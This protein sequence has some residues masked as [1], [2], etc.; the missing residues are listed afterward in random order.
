MKTKLSLLV[1]CCLTTHLL[2]AQVLG[3]QRGLYIN[4]FVDLWHNNAPGHINNTINTN[5]SILGNTTAE[6][7]LL[8]YCMENHITYLVLYDMAKIFEGTNSAT[9]A[10][11][12]TALKQ[13]ICKAKR[14]YCIKYVGASIGLDTY[15]DVQTGFGLKQTPPYIFD[16]ILHDTDLYDSLSYVEDT[17]PTDD[18]RFA[19]AELIK[20]SLRI[21]FMNGLNSSAAWTV[22][23]DE[24]VD[25]LVTEYEF[26]NG[27]DF[28]DPF[29]ALD[30][31]GLI[32]AVDAIRNTH[33]A[34]TTNSKMYIETY[35]GRLAATVPSGI[36]A[37]D[38]TEYIDGLDVDG[39]RRID[40]IL[41]DYYTNNPI[42]VY[43]STNNFYQRR[44]LNF[45]ESTGGSCAGAVST[46]DNTDYHPIF[47]AQSPNVGAGVNSNSL[48]GW[49]PGASDRNIFTVEREFYNNF[50]AD[51]ST[52]VHAVNK[53]NDVQPGACQWLGQAYMVKPLNHPIT[54][55]SS[56]VPC[57]STG[58]QNVTLTYQGPIENADN[59]YTGTNYRY[60]VRN[61]LNVPF[62]P[63][64]GSASGVVNFTANTTGVNNVVYSLPPGNYEASLTLTY[65]TGCYYTYTENIVVSEEFNIHALNHPGNIVGPIDLCANEHVILQA[66]WQSTASGVSYAWMLNGVA[67]S[68]ANTYEYSATL[69]GDYVCTIT[70]TT[71]ST[72]VSNVIHVNLMASPPRFIVATCSS[73]CVTLTVQPQLIGDTYSWQDLSNASTFPS[74]SSFPTTICN[75][76]YPTFTVTV[77]NGGCSQT[78]WKD[79]DDDLLG[80]TSPTASTLTSDPDPADVCPG[81]LVELT[82]NASTSTSFL[83]S[84]GQVSTPTT[85]L[86]VIEVS[87]P[88]NYFVITHNASGCEAISN[89]IDVDNFAPELVLTAPV[90]SVCDAGNPV[91]LTVTGGTTTTIYTWSTGVT[92]QGS[93][94]ATLTVNPTVTTTYS[95]TGTDSHGC[96]NT[97]SVTINV[98]T[99][100]GCYSLSQSVVPAKT[101]A[102]HPVT[103]SIEVCNNTGVSRIVNLKDA[104]P[105]TTGSGTTFVYLSGT[106]PSAA[107]TSTGATIVLPASPQCTTY[108]VTGYFVKIHDCDETGISHSSFTNTTTLTPPSPATVLTSDVCATIL[109]D[110][111]MRIVGT[112]TTCEEDDDVTIALNIHNTLI[113]VD[114][115][116][117]T[118]IYPSFLIPPNTSQLVASL[119]YPYTLTPPPVPTIG[120][121]TPTT[122]V[123]N[124]VSYNQVSLQVSFPDPI[125]SNIYDW[126]Y[127]IKFKID[128]GR[129]AGQNQFFVA[130]DGNLST[131]SLVGS[132]ANFTQWTQ[133]SDIFLINCDGVT[134][135]FDASFSVSD[136]TCDNPGE[137][138]FTPLGS[139]P[140]TAIHIWDLG[141]DRRTPIRGENTVTWD[142]LADYTD[143]TGVP[144][145]RANGNYTFKVKHTVI[146][147][148]NFSIDSVIVTV[149]GK[150]DASVSKTD[151]ICAGAWAGTA[152]VT[153]TFGT[154]PYEY[155]W[156]TGATTSS[157]SGLEAGNY[158]VTV[159]DDIRCEKVVNFIIADPSSST[160]PSCVTASVSNTSCITGTIVSWTAATGCVMGYN[161]YYGTDG[162]GT[163]TPTQNAL[164]LGNVTS[165]ILPIL[166]SNT[167][168]YYQ[169]LPYDFNSDEITGCTIS[170]FTSGGAVAFT[171]TLTTPYVE[172]FESA[173]VPALPC[174]ITMMDSNFPVDGFDWRTGTGSACGSGTK[175]MVI[176]KNSNN[177]TAKDD[178]FF[179]APLIL[180]KR[181]LYR[182][183]YDIKVDA[184]QTENVEIYISSSPDPA[185]MMATAALSMRYISSTSCTTITSDDYVEYTSGVYYVG[186]RAV[187]TANKGNI[188]IDNLKVSMIRTT[189]LTDTTIGGTPK[190]CE[191]ILS[192]CSPIYVESY[193]SATSFKFKFENLDEGISKEYTFNYAANYPISNFLLSVANS[194]NRLDMGRPYMVYVG[195]STGGAYSPYG[196]GCEV[197][198]NPIPTTGLISSNCGSTI[199][200]LNNPV[201]TN[202][203]NICGVVDYFYKFTETGVG[204]IETQRNSST[205]TFLTVWI[206]SPGVKYSTTYSAE[207]KLKIGNEWG[208]YGSACNVN[209]GTS[210]LT[211]LQS[212]FCNYTLPTF[213]TPVSCIAVPGATDYRYH[214]TGPGGYDRTFPRNSSLTNWYFTWTNSSPYMQASTTYNVEVASKA[215]GVW[216]SY[217]NVCT[218]TTP[219]SLTRLAD[220]TTLEIESESML[221][222]DKQTSLAM[223]VFP[224]PNFNN[225][226]FSI[227][228]SGIYKSN[229]KIKLSIFNLVGANLYKSLVETKEENRFILKPE[230]ILPSGVYLVEADVNGNKLRT[231]LVIE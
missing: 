200:N 138:T 23:S 220:T 206:A 60:V 82:T 164:Y 219:S 116:D 118:I 41:S 97:S 121:P 159:Y 198:I 210:P 114:Y 27:I 12:L 69:D 104:L 90:T 191:A 96:I 208:A 71:C 80:G 158:S 50:D 184:T 57:P 195:A 170:S 51:N 135:F 78:I 213:A 180:T 38:I 173:N 8:A 154:P 127:R 66:N 134:N 68:G 128:A 72:K 102:G 179:S 109:K 143:N 223:N 161:V 174:G 74:A 224:N 205:A 10:G 46:V 146:D 77:S 24:H 17:I 61:S 124:G 28:D 9:L 106:L 192:S 157:I 132:S 91:V 93:T 149:V 182:V 131:L 216:S 152:S 25:I 151:N 31:V 92:G 226:Q 112:S 136:P 40:R 33:N 163:A 110:C 126:F 229:Q 115:I 140:S 113:D 176:S 99:T 190:S 189:N 214:I 201:T 3:N 144:Q 117:V 39:E 123:I 225:E 53:Q 21:A 83:W 56:Q 48:G 230:I 79:I 209:T 49:F 19:S 171:P 181:K 133:A 142:Y 5:S 168:Y 177:T 145:S 70:T 215:G 187:S 35:I 43:N 228:I 199:T 125:S 202:L 221:T 67:I 188:Y 108:T 34:I 150:L 207:V 45:C 185:T 13:F 11:K 175:H 129:P 1:A 44:F 95:V 30:Y 86:A 169:V 166:N 94:Y 107:L 156:S 212:T 183:E 6:N 18:E 85:P 37:C 87:N 111:P 172:D 42:G 14:D 76:N 153:A 167:L 36:T 65:G 103:F 139:V 160:P 52:N 162:G 186:I 148:G 165:A 120:T 15:A 75:D 2:Y 122:T 105:P 47:S 130:V 194:A 211:E 203:T 204:S 218:I 147:G 101:Y 4:Q 59:Y 81:D 26:W 222:L 178:W 29:D 55:Q 100:D 54:F 84:T 89:F 197:T 137:F 7:T 16:S 98:P 63:N 227:E 141:D 196:W 62:S 20:L 155:S 193:P 119:S 64:T 88:V 22:C 231:K 32:D 58:N 73:G 217:G